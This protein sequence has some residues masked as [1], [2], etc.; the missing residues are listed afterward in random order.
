[1]WNIPWKKWLQKS[2]MYSGSANVNTDTNEGTG[3]LAD[4]QPASA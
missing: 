4:A 2:A 1:L 3:S